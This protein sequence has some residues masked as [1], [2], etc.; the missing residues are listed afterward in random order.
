[1]TDDRHRFSTLKERI[2]AAQVGRLVS[3]DSIRQIRSSSSLNF[4]RAA[5]QQ[6]STILGEP[7]LIRHLLQLIVMLLL[8]VH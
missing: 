4:F 2:Y 5:A 3:H 7:D 6:L 1:M 8:S